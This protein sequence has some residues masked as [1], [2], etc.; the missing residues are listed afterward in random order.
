MISLAKM[1][2]LISF[3]GKGKRV[4]GI[5]NR[6]N[7]VESWRKERRDWS[8]KNKTKKGISSSKRV[9]VWKD[10]YIKWGGRRAPNIS[11][12][13][14]AILPKAL[15]AKLFSVEI[16]LTYWVALNICVFK[17]LQYYWNKYFSFYKRIWWVGGVVAWVGEI[18][19]MVNR[20]G[21]I[22]NDNIV[23]GVTHCPGGS[24]NKKSACI[25]GGLGSV[26]G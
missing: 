26:S 19:K 2:G 8:F 25:E 13:Y 1:R 7:S 24:D 15:M 20:S 6:E 22:T 17:W 23:V 3:W 21:R 11:S 10:S 14:L 9:K 4:I 16:H 18:E 5:F 12:T